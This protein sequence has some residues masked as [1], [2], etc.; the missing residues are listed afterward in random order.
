MTR[1]R[2]LLQGYLL[3]T[4]GL[5]GWQAA[6]ASDPVRPNSLDEEST[7][8]SIIRS[9]D[10]FTLHWYPAEGLHYWAVTFS[11]EQ[12]MTTLDT[13]AITADTFYVHNDAEGSFSLGF[14]R[15]DPIDIEPPPDTTV[16]IQSFY[17]FPQ[18]PLFQSVPN[19]DT[20]PAG[21]AV[22]DD[23]QFGESGQSLLMFG[24]TW[25][26]IQVPPYHVDSTDTWAVAMKLIELGEL[27]A[28]GVADSENFMHY[29][30]WGKEAPQSLNW[31]TT[32]QGYFDSD[33]WVDIHL[34]IGED[35]QGR[36]G[37]APNITHIYFIND[38]DTVSTSGEVRFDEVRD[39]TG[40]LPKDPV[41]EF[42]WSRASNTNPDSITVSFR[43]F[44]YDLDSPILTHHWDFGDG[45]TSSQYHPRHTYAA[46]GRYPVSLTVTDNDDRTAWTT[47]A[48]LDSPVTAEREM[49]FAFTG[50]VILGRGYENNNGIID[51]WGVDTIF[52]PTLPWTQT[53][54]L[55]CM[56]LECPFTTSG[57]RHPTKGIVF[58]ANPSSV[59]G[60]VNA[61]VDFVTLANNHVFDYLIPG[62]NETMN[63]LDQAGIV[64]NGAGLN[65]ELARRV[66]FMSRNGISF[67][68]LSFSDRTGS[69]NNYQPFLDAG[70]SR[71]GFAMW[72][73][74]AIDAT[75]A[76]AAALSDF[77]VINTHSGSEY[78]LEPFLNMAEE[79]DPLGDEDMILELI[80]DTLERELRQYAID[81]GAE[82][83]IAHH[84][85]IIQGFEVYNGKLIAHS[86]GNF[87]FDLTYAE[88]MPTV[89][90]RTH[91]DGNIG[92]DQAT[93][94][95][96]YINHWI[97]QPARGE[98]AR[99]ILDYESEM[100]RRLDTWLVRPPGGDSAFVVFDTMAVTRSGMDTTVTLPIALSGSWW[101]SAPHKLAQDGY[102]VSTAVTNVPNCEVRYGRE[103]LLFGNM[104]DEG[105]DDWLLNSGDE[106]Y[107]T[108]VSHNGQRSIR[109][110][111]ASGTPGNVITFNQYRFPLPVGP[112]YTFCGWIKT[113]NAEDAVYQVEYYSQRSGGTYISQVNVGSPVDGTTEWGFYRRDLSPPGSTRYIVI[114]MSLNSPSSETG[115]AWFDDASLIEWGGWMPVPASAPFPNDFH[116]VQVRNAANVGDVVLQYRREWVEATEL[117]VA[118]QARR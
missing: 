73:R 108:D 58:K 68:M 104:E 55:T 71:A 8:L 69:Y 66:K 117:I 90:L 80:P 89:I 106:G 86:L 33:E 10:G 37:Y 97:P 21:Y 40:A 77:V 13:L 29:L 63:V 64:H 14:F 42:Q 75:V 111:R 54:D 113:E 38:N 76:E 51:N 101:T 6:F 118:E 46:H 72:N 43:S 3:L 57:T 96:V 36:F 82:L 52:A 112:D 59:S 35:W 31:I 48:I 16:V 50:D 9:D 110:R 94:H 85:H 17:E 62:M 44:A 30:I 79:F 20:E 11:Q 47:Q 24:N 92:V 2:S 98:L 91:F 23:D 116:Y 49:W 28:F 105:A 78:S 70:R 107:V 56:N 99:N 26:R 41:A 74:A 102:I 32:Y 53:A 25:K 65:D 103:R 1:L 34:P 83:V 95:P 27:H 87:I 81:M 115:F 114:R 67:G 15:V 61:G 60:L 39:I 7:L 19:E 22:N 45:V 109:L 4:F 93:V 5:C 88:T 18:I 12:T 84:P 100:S